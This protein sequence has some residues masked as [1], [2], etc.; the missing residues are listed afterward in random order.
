MVMVKK[1]I[2]FIVFGLFLSISTPQVFCSQVVR[3]AVFQDLNKVNLESSE[4]LSVKQ[5]E[6]NSIIIDKLQAKNTLI[7]STNTGFNIAG[8][9]INSTRIEI[10][11]DNSGEI[12]LDGRRFRGAIR[13]IKKDGSS[14]F[15]VNFVDLEDYIRGVLYHEIS[16]LW[17]FETIKAQTVIVRTFALTQIENNKNKEFDLTNNIYS[18]MYGGRTSERFRT[19]Q[20]IDKTQGEVLTFNGKI[21]PTYYHATCA[22]RTEDAN[23][24]WDID[25]PPLR[26]IICSYC[27]ESPH[28]KWSSS[29]EL[30]KIEAKLKAA[31]FKVGNIEDIQISLCSNAH[32]ILKLEIVSD[33]GELSISGKD[34]REALG[35]NILRSSNFT[36]EIK[37]GQAQFSGFGWGHGVG[38]CQ[39]GAYFMGKKGFSY[40]EILEFYYPGAKIK[41]YEVN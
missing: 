35:P 18:Q 12:S 33:T 21:F 32:R 7:K 38:M 14:F 26:G 1:I 5:V 27:K 30:K 36:L 28:F 13:L 15:V 9:D 25:L 6:D 39:W 31:H 24:L 4:L 3:V 23:N 34:F 41:K 20:A 22:G 16:H 29:L 8:K 17:P 10:I 37:H 19:N 40:K 2:S 11:A